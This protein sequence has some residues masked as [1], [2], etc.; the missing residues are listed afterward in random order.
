MRRRPRSREA[1]GVGDVAGERRG[2]AHGLIPRLKVRVLHGP[3]RK[4]VQTA[5]I[6]PGSSP[7]RDLAGRICNPIATVRADGPRGLD[8]R[9]GLPNPLGLEAV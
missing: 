9:S 7:G 1:A 3:F 5:G 8:V 6:P 4:C 2:P